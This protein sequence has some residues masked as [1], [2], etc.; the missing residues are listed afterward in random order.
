MAENS[1]SLYAPVFGSWF[2]LLLLI[3]GSML[4]SFNAETRERIAKSYNH[5]SRYGKLAALFCNCTPVLY[6]NVGGYIF[7][8]LALLL[9]TLIYFSRLEND[10]N[11]YLLLLLIPVNV[12]L[13]IILINYLRRKLVN[14]DVNLQRL[15]SFIP[16]SCIFYGTKMIFVNIWFVCA[17]ISNLLA[18]IQITFFRN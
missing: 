14:K 5:N 17:V 13:Q 7:I 3:Y 18:A 11:A 8:G 2:I 10:A 16:T 9:Q 4:A 15:K 1:S 6:N 12:G